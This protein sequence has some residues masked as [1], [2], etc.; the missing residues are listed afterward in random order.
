MGTRASGYPLTNGYPD[1]IV[2]VPGRTQ[3]VMNN[4]QLDVISAAVKACTF[5]V[6]ALRDRTIISSVSYR[7]RY[8]TYRMESYRLILYRGKP[9][10]TC[11]TAGLAAVN[12]SHYTGQLE[13]IR[14]PSPTRACRLIVHNM[15]GDWQGGRRKETATLHQP[16][17]DTKTAQPPAT[18]DAVPPPPA[19]SDDNSLNCQSL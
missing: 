6:V 8:W 15:G 4:S 5:H 17:C 7:N 9:D 13:R 1:N 16:A 3:V 2:N 14:V 10:I 19:G 18:N 12:R 11:I